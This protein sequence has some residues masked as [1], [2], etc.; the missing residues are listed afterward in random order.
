MP[1]IKNNPINGKFIL[2][3]VPNINGQIVDPI[4]PDAKAVPEPNPATL[5]GNNSTL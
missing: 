2:Y 3:K 4:V 1:Y 5:E